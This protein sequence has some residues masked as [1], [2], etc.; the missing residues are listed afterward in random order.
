MTR[1]HYNRVVDSLDWRSSP[2]YPYLKY[3]TTNGLFFKVDDP[4]KFE[5]QRN[6]V[7]DLVCDR[8]RGGAND[9]IRLFV[10]PEP[11]K[12]KKLNSST[13][14]LISSVSIVDQIID[15]M[16]FGP[17]NQAFIDDCLR[18]PNKAGWSHLKGGYRYMPRQT[19]T[20]I[21]KS[22]WDWSVKIWLVEME[23]EVRKRLC[24]NMNDEWDRLAR[25]RYSQL[26]EKPVFVTSGGTLLR[27]ASPGV[28]KSGCVNT[29][30]SNSIMQ[31]ILHVVACIELGL[32]LTPIMSMGDDTLQ[33][34]V[35]GISE[36]VDVLNRYSHVK[37][38]VAS[39]EFAGMRFSRT[40]E[41]LYKGKHAFNLL[42]LD[43]ELVQEVAMSYTILYHRSANRNWIRKFFQEMGASVPSLEFCDW[44][45]EGDD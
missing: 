10:K 9:P 13:Y 33:E 23:L 44:V 3:G 22:K 38:Y 41:P 19:W 30:S 2:G 14:R 27:Q 24:S 1:E 11:L 7:W 28:M 45:Y 37:H 29:I 31:V 6:Y 8:V 17:C 4:E 43:P 16:L 42:H 40:I 32:S 34:P 12:E 5:Q 15:Q 36:Y 25:M 39:N 26:F 21:D 35:D 18:I 20:A